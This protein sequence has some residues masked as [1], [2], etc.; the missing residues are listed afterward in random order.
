MIWQA[1][2]FDWTGF[3]SLLIVTVVGTELPQTMTLVQYL[4]QYCQILNRYNRVQ[5][6]T[7]SEQGLGQKNQLKEAQHVRLTLPL[8]SFPRKT[9][10]TKRVRKLYFLKIERL[11]SA[12]GPSAI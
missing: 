10:L 8:Q 5:P 3:Q 9:K 6:S 11:D 12:L 7:N 4:V 1:S 2:T